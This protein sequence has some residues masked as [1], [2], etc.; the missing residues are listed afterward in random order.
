MLYRSCLG[1]RTH[2]RPSRAMIFEEPAT[3][4]LQTNFQKAVAGRPRLTPRSASESMR[5]LDSDAGGKVGVR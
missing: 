5:V 2:G 1:H 3:L 4:P